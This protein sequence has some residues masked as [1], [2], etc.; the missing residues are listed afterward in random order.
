[1]LNKGWMVRDAP[2]ANLAVF[3]LIMF[4]RGGGRGGG[5]THFKKTAEFVMA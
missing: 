4:D 1:M 2:D 5:Q 3:F